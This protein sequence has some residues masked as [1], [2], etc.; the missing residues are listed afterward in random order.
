[1]D[2]VNDADSKISIIDLITLWR[3]MIKTKID[4]FNNLEY[5]HAM[6]KSI[7]DNGK[8]ENLIYK[9]TAKSK[10][11]KLLTPDI[12]FSLPLVIN[13]DTSILLN[14]I[15]KALDNCIEEY[16]LQNYEQQIIDKYKKE[17]NLN[18]HIN[19]EYYKYWSTEYY[20]M[21]CPDT[22]EELK[23]KMDNQNIIEASDT[24]LKVKEKLEK[25]K[26]LTNSIDG[27]NTTIGNFRLTMDLINDRISFKSDKDNDI[28]YSIQQNSE[29]TNKEIYLLATNNIT[30]L[31]EFNNKINDK[32]FYLYNKNKFIQIKKSHILG[33]NKLK[34]T[35]RIR[36]T[37]HKYLRKTKKYKNKHYTYSK[38][39]QYIQK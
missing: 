18:N 8:F 33:G 16:T 38:Q 25:V 11:I 6:L 22:K 3:L 34:N 35:N 29:I 23:I 37:R 19:N 9:G 31:L 21:I 20:K 12:G 13:I 14:I 5:K 1:M 7:K 39:K 32:A 2:T 28:F 10:A 15:K 27:S 17:Y 24:I 4:N 36:S 26:Q 30:K